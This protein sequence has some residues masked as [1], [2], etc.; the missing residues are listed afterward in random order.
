MKSKVYSW[1]ISPD[2][3]ADLE[4]EARREKLSLAA[5][6]EQMA[7][8]R[9]GQQRSHADTGDA[10]QERLHQEAARWIGSIAGGNPERSESVRTVVR[11]R[12]ARKYGRS[13]SD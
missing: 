8:E 12:L 4:L 3:K 2:L 9:L 5:L 11:K 13:R 7:L 6:L 1:R 10:A